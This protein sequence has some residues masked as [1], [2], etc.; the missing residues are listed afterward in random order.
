MNIGPGTFKVFIVIWN[1]ASLALLTRMSSYA[2]TVTVNR[3]GLSALAGRDQQTS[4][5]DGS[6]AWALS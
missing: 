4:G 3:P 6:R 5:P 2:A 1:C